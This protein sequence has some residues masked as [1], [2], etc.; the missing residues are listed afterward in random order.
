MASTGTHS[1]LPANVSRLDPSRRR[2]PIAPTFLGGEVLPFVPPTP[3]DVNRAMAAT[4]LQDVT[5]AA[6]FSINRPDVLIA[7]L[8]A[9]HTTTAHRA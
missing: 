3:P 4:L 1:S 8:E 7:M 2:T 5:T 6:A 9:A